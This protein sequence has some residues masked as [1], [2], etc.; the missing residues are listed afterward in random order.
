[1]AVVQDTRTG[2]VLA[3]ADYPTF[4]A[5]RPLDSPEDDLGSRALSDVYE[6]GSVQKVLTVASLIDAGPGHAPH[7][8]PRAAR[9]WTGRTASSTTGSATE[10]SG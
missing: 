9:S 4:D 7:Q 3:L 2:E 6:P 5:T 8:D 10:T 1:M